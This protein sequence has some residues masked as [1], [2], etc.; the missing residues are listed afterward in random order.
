MDIALVKVE[1]REILATLQAHPEIST[2]LADVERDTAGEVMAMPFLTDAIQGKA[3]L[4]IV[5]GDGVRAVFGT[6]L[7]ESGHKEMLARGLFCTGKEMGEWVHLI[8]DLEAWGRAEGCKRLKL[9]ARR[10]WERALKEYGYRVT[11]VELS[12]EL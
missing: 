12:K 6:Y 4:W 2:L 8:R 3:Q 11:H 7:Y 10:G 5:W 1:P 9:L